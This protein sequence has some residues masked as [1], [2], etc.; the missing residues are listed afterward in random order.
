MLF[1]I[2]VFVAYAVY[3]WA[4]LPHYGNSTLIP[5]VYVHPLE[6][7]LQQSKQDFECL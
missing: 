4:L 2:F 3:L 6:T 1:P 7:I 5:F